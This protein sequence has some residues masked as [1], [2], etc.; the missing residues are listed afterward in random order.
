[1]FRSYGCNNLASL[2]DTHRLKYCAF[3]YTQSQEKTTPDEVLQSKFEEL[4]NAMDLVGFSE[5]VWE[6]YSA[7]SAQY[8]LHFIYF[9]LLRSWS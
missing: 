2:Y 1:M 7:T 5:E 4:Q 8:Y 6:L 3:R 9:L